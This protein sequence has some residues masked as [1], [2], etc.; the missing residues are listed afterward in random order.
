[1]LHAFRNSSGS[2][3]ISAMLG[4]KTGSVFGCVTRPELSDF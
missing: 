3:A 1:M 2:L 4:I